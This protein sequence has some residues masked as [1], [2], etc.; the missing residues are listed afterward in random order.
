MTWSLLARDAEGRFGLA[1]AS[2]FFAVGSL[3]IHSQRGVGA[4]A[5]QALANPLYGPAALALLAQG[6][7]AAA[8]VA[9]LTAADPGQAQRQVHVLGAHG[10]A[11]VHTGE[12]C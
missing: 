1:I 4:V 7:A 9:A 3:C 8:V 5:T 10:A 12:G 6:H 2:R 11:A